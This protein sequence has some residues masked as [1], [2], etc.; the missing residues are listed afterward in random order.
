[1]FNRQVVETFQSKNEVIP[2]HRL[3][4]RRSVASCDPPS[5][6]PAKPLTPL[7]KQ[8]K[9][10]LSSTTTKNSKK[11]TVSSDPISSVKNKHRKKPLSYARAL[12]QNDSQPLHS[13]VSPSS[14]SPGSTDSVSNSPE[15]QDITTANALAATSIDLPYKDQYKS[16]GQRVTLVPPFFSPVAVVTPRR[17]FFRRE[18]SNS[19]SREFMITPNNIS[20]KSV[21]SDDD[22][23]S[24]FDTNNNYIAHEYY[25]FDLNHDYDYDLD[26][27]LATE[28]YRYFKGKNIHID[29]VEI[30]AEEEEFTKPFNRIK[31][32]RR[33]RREDR[34]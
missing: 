5:P 4:R 11:N 12:L 24:Q 29:G 18:H 6:S 33:L 8:P 10:G 22:D 19:S 2:C 13:I 26:D 9:S 1:M 28:R 32:D 34:M 20:L 3:R 31:L 7:R 23:T 27:D 16:N 25:D 14:S 30:T 21:D 17:G 15:L